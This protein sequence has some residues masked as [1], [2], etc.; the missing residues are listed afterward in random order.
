M[1]IYIGGLDIYIYIHTQTR[2][3]G[4]QGWDSVENQMAKNIKASTKGRV[5]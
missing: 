5:M 1:Y 2:I 4:V 3:C